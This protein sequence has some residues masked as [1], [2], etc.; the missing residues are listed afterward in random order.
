MVLKAFRLLPKPARNCLTVFG[1]LAY[2][3]ELNRS[4]G[5]GVRVIDSR[6]AK[7]ADDG[8]RVLPLLEM[9]FKRQD[10]GKVSKK[11]GA[12]AMVSLEVAAAATLDGEYDALITPPI[13]KKAVNLA[14][15]HIPGHTEF[16]A[17]MC[18]D[19]PVA[20]ML[21]SPNLKVVVAT[22]HVAVKDVPGALDSAKLAGLMTIIDGSMKRMTGKRPTIAVCGL[23]PHASD[24]GLFGDE[25]KRIIAP[26]ITIAKRKGMKVSGPYP[27]DTMF[28]PR[29]LEKYDVALAM[30]HDQG[31]IPVKA[32][33]FGKTVNITLGL[34]ILRVS[35][36]H[37]A[38]FDIA[39]K[40]LADGAPMAHAIMTA[41]SILRGR[42]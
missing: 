17:E 36:D 38:A 9:G 31:L 23:N 35:V 7:R 11:M 13:H 41:I 20:M 34:P 26:A 8:L 32:L 15:Y 40:N 27:A 42:F 22:T 14:G 29:A 21:A 3:E 16:L 37:G 4:T 2:F 1:D 5:S 30:Y 10:F 28:T 19:I 6:A 24:Q 12:A 39:G 18:G 25:E 33:G